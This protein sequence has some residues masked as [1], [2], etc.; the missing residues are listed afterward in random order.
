MQNVSKHWPLVLKNEFKA[1]RAHSVYINVYSDQLELQD[2]SKMCQDALVQYGKCS[3]MYSLVTRRYF[4][5]DLM[6]DRHNLVKSL[7]GQ[8]FDVVN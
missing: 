4:S 1:S 6:V 2:I 7:P 8:L 5:S 3:V